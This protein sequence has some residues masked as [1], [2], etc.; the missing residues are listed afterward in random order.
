M[1]AKMHGSKIFVF[2]LLMAATL[3][4]AGCAPEYVRDYNNISVERFDSKPLT[5]TDMEH[6]VRLAAFQEEWQKADVVEPGHIVA[7]KEDEDGK[8]SASVD[9]IYTATQF[10]IHYKDSRGFRYDASDHKIEH[11]Y[12]SMVDDLRGR[13]L[14][15]VQEITPGG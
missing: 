5:L 6:A 12:L 10:S 2:G 9:V 7:T 1:T 4:I 3:L 15:A 11:H 13:I 8:R 14:D